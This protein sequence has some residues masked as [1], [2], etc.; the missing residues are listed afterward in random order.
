MD[1]DDIV[2]DIV[3]EYSRAIMNNEPFNSAHEG[4]AVLLE[5]VDELKYEVWKNPTKRDIKKMKEEA[6]Q[7]GAMA[8]RFINDICNKERKTA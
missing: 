6:I 8:I 2:D 3:Q 5:E 1:I 4:Y 7:V